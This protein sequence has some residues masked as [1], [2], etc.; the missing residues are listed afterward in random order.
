[1]RLIIR[2]VEF[3]AIPVFTCVDCGAEGHGDT[4][5][6]E[7]DIHEDPIGMGAHFARHANH[8]HMQL[9][10]VGWAAYGRGVARC[11]KCIK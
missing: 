2:K 4:Y 10:P 11:P 6:G 8:V 7:M 5:N 3:K 9:I 1:M